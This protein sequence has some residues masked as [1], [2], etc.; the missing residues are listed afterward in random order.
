MIA[1]NQPAESIEEQGS[2]NMDKDLKQDPGEETKAPGPKKKTVKKVVKKTPKKSPPQYECGFAP[3]GNSTVSFN[4]TY[5]GITETYNLSL[6]NKIF[7]IPEKF[8][9]EE[10]KRYRAA[11]LANN[12][13]DITVNHSA[14]FNKQ[15][16][17][18][19]YKAMHPEHTDRNPIN[20]TTA[21][22][23]RDSAGNAILENNG[24]QKIEQVTILNGI[25]KTDDVKVYEALIKSGF[26]D[27]GTKTGGRNG[28]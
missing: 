16:G 22:V 7:I 13:R 4:H 21:V 25:V 26:Y 3:P 9:D 18:T 20:A 27:A 19:T 28:N 12:F 14:V 10:K 15:T 17:K 1:L 11:L 23:L 5:M 2:H 6:E 24:T 8:S